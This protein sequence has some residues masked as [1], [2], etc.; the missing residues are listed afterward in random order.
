MGFGH[1]DQLT[2]HYEGIFC[3]ALIRSITTPHLVMNIRARIQLATYHDD[4]L[5]QVVEDLIISID[6]TR[7][8][9]RT[10]VDCAL[11][12]L[13]KDKGEEILAFAERLK[14]L[15]H[16]SWRLR[17]DPSELENLQEPPLVLQ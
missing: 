8:E 13:Q 2:E 15:H 6:G 17:L 4:D 3:D 1:L 5:T 11:E 10:R 7:E 14:C 16:R 12:E 9:C